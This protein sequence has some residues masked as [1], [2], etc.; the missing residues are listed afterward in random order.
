MWYFWRFHFCLIWHIAITFWCWVLGHNKLPNLR[1]HG[2]ALGWWTL[3]GL[4]GNAWDFLSFSIE[5][6]CPGNFLSPEQTGM[7]S[8]SMLCPHSCCSYHWPPLLE[9]NIW[10]SKS[11]HLASSTETEGGMDILRTVHFDLLQEEALSMRRRK[12]LGSPYL[13]LFALCAS[14]WSVGCGPGEILS[15]ARN[16]Q[17]CPI[18]LSCFSTFLIPQSSRLKQKQ[19]TKKLHDDFFL[20]LPFVPND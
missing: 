4:S 18:A 10:L 12:S 13:T 9:E 15:S 2:V 8:Y 3:P 11:S 14:C 1:W 17:E 5:D 7:A 16:F 19:K 20:D 6:L